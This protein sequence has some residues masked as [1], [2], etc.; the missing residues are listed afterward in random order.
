MSQ[1]L[2]LSSK[3]N[4]KMFSI[5]HPQA[6]WLLLHSPLIFKSSLKDLTMNTIVYR[7]SLHFFLAGQTFVSGYTRD[8]K[9]H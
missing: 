4:L 6:G 9:V 2:K 7:V 8:F 5:C 3:R 1:A